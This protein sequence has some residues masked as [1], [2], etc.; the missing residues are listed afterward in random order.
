MTDDEREYLE[1]T[2]SVFQ[3]LLNTTA[4]DLECM[5]PDRLSLVRALHEARYTGHTGRWTVALTVGDVATMHFLM[6]L[7]F[8]RGVSK[9]SATRM[10]H[11]LRRE[12]AVYQKIDDQ[13]RKEME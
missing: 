10:T 2:M 7:H 6:Q 5:L 4:Q 1:L 8:A 12:S 9:I 11:Q 3:V 13:H